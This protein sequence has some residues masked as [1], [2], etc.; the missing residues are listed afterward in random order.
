M[1][2]IYVVEHGRYEY[3]EKFT[4]WA[5]AAAFCNHEIEEGRTVKVWME[6]ELI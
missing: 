5:E 4:S 2:K 6:I 1:R 3:L